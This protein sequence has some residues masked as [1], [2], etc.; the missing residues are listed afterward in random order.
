M[1]QLLRYAPSKSGSKRILISRKQR[2]KVDFRVVSVHSVYSLLYIQLLCVVSNN[3][4]YA[5]T[6]EATKTHLSSLIDNNSK[7]ECVK[8]YI[9][10]ILYLGMLRAERIFL[11]SSCD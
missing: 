9:Y 6:Y 2:A 3:G 5:Y 4:S 8:S 11:K 7:K 1:L 10:T